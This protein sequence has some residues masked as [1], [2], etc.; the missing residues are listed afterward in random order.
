MD[1]GGKAC[2]YVVSAPYCSD[3]SCFDFFSKTSDADCKAYLPTCYLSGESACAAT[4]TGDCDTYTN[5]TYDINQNAAYCSS[6]VER[7]GNTC[8]YM[9]FSS[10]C[11]KRSCD[12]IIPNSNDAT[13]KAYLPTCIYYPPRYS[14]ILHLK[15][16]CSV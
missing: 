1:L 9:D 2:G 12:D 5:I 13:C 7:E 15:F 16:D 8:G 4:G 11:T 6:Q 10:S 3:K 14:C